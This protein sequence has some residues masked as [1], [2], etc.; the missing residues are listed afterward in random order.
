MNVRYCYLRVA[1]DALLREYTSS[2]LIQFDCVPVITLNSM[3]TI[4]ELKMHLAL[5][6]GTVSDKLRLWRFEKRTND[7]YR[8]L[9]A[10]HQQHDAVTL[11]QMFPAFINSGNFIDLYLEE[12][13]R[14]PVAPLMADDVI[15][16]FKYFEPNRFTT[17]VV[18][19][20][21]VNKNR[22][23]ETLY[24]EMCT[25]ACQP[26]NSNIRIVEETRPNACIN[27]NPKHTI[28]QA[29]LI[30]GDIIVFQVIDDRTNQTLDQ[31][32]QELAKNVRIHVH[33][34]EIPE[35]EIGTIIMNKDMTYQE[36]L[37]RI[38]ESLNIPS[39]H[40]ELTGEKNGPSHKP[41]RRGKTNFLKDMIKE[42]KKLYVSMSKQSQIVC[43]QNEISL[44]RSLLEQN[45]IPLPSPPSY[46]SMI[47]T[48]MPGGGISE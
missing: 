5:H 13:K 12:A 15:L 2:G 18:G 28:A 3:M 17:R 9:I 11:Q 4:A 8:P 20:M 1:T 44:L 25:M 16:F 45:G 29:G 43:L 26:S 34:L 42:Q 36:A 48:L 23:I 10:I 46:A 22:V 37:E 32:Y 47:T 7:T 19:S 35:L 39:T 41:F 40:I 33:S 30:R 14:A 38:A 31:F 6:Y 27:L 24:S 21:V